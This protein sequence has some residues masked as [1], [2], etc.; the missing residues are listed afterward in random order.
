M[1]GHFQMLYFHTFNVVCQQVR[2]I[3]TKVF[4]QLLQLFL[5]P[6]IL[7]T[8]THVDP[9]VNADQRALDQSAPASRDILEALQTADQSVS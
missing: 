7:V 9:T 6:Q 1:K 4:Y 2:E 3:I 5:S 8:Q